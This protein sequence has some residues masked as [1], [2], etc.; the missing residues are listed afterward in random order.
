MIYIYDVYGIFIY[1]ICMIYDAYDTYDVY[2]IHDIYDINLRYMRYMTQLYLYIYIYICFDTVFVLIIWYLYTVYMIYIYIWH[3]QFTY[4]TYILPFQY[5]CID[6]NPSKSFTC[7]CNS[8]I[9]KWITVGLTLDSVHSAHMIMKA[10]K[11]WWPRAVAEMMVDEC[12]CTGKVTG[13][14]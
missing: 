12:W 2:D 3:M 6:F 14:A 5:T 1:L 7:R 8:T 11:V 13:F 9:S 4:P 10:R